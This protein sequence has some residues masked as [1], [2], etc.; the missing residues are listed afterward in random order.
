M[1]RCT[2][3]G[4]M[5]AHARLKEAHTFWA[6]RW[7]VAQVLRGVPCFH[8]ALSPPHPLHL[9]EAFCC[10]EHLLVV[11]SCSSQTAQEASGRDLPKPPCRKRQAA[12]G[13]FRQRC[14]LQALCRAHLMLLVCDCYLYYELAQLRLPEHSQPSPEV[15]MAVPHCHRRGSCEHLSPLPSN[16]CCWEPHCTLEAVR[17]S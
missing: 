6:Q 12:G 7:I 17:G 10:L 15:L 3:S 5:L 11:P 2:T 8:S 14:T 16:N 9:Q 1:K 4:H 13:Q